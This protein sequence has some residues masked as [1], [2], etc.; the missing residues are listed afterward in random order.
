[1]KKPAR[2]KA[3]LSDRRAVERRASA[4]CAAAAADALRQTD[5][6]RRLRDAAMRTANA[7]GLSSASALAANCELAARIMTAHGQAEHRAMVAGKCHSD[8]AFER[9]AA[10]K[11]VTMV[12][13]KNAVEER[14]LAVKREAELPPLQIRSM[15]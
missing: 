6:A 7:T 2:L 15:R 14:L 12:I 9:R 5:M 4:A 8:A 11:A 1:M 13:D 10:R 3:L